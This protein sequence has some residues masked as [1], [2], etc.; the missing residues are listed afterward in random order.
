[1]PEG[2]KIQPPAAIRR[3]TGEKKQGRRAT[4]SLGEKITSWFG[5][6]LHLLVDSENELPLAWKVTRASAGDRPKL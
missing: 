4:G 3:P 2:A 5:Y 6:K 1:M